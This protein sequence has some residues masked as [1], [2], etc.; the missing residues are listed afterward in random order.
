[1]LKNLFRWLN[2]IVITGLFVG[3]AGKGGNIIE[4]IRIGEQS[5]NVLKIKIDVITIAKAEV[6]VEYWEDSSGI[7]NKMLSVVSPSAL[8]HSLVL[9]NIIPQ[10]NYSFDIVT[11][12]N[13]VKTISKK[14][15]FQSRPLPLWLKDQF[16]YSC[17]DPALLPRE[18]KDGWMLLNKRETPGVKDFDYPHPEEKAIDYS[19][20]PFID[21]FPSSQHKFGPFQPIISYWKK[22]DLKPV[23]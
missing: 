14:Y 11:V 23:Y 15:T 6:F 12:S 3:C 4:E 13:N 18:F 17:N 21:T 2:V 5:N 7:N 8:S 20:G 10:T 19:V 9:C 22:K 16:K 1:M